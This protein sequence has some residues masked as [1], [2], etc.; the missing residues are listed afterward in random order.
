MNTNGHELQRSFAEVVEMIQAARNRAYR[1]I[2]TILVDLYW[3]VGE[4][5]SHRI[6]AGNWQKIAHHLN[7]K[8]NPP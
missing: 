6:D 5:V 4:Y 8:G 2:N 1:A 3:Q 7:H